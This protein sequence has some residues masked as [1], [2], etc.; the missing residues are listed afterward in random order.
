MINERGSTWHLP[1]KLFLM[2]RG[3]E[4]VPA[5]TKIYRWTI[6]ER[7][8]DRHRHAY[9]RCQCECGFVS[10]AVN[11]SLMKRGCTKSCGCLREDTQ[12]KLRT[13]RK[14]RRVEAPN[15]YDLRYGK[16]EFY[17]DKV[18]EKGRKLDFKIIGRWFGHLKV[19]S[20]SRT[21]RKKSSNGVRTLWKCYCEICGETKEMDRA[22]LINGNSLS[23]GCRNGIQRKISEATGY[24]QST[25]SLVLNNRDLDKYKGETITKIRKTA[26]E[27]GYYE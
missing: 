1:R 13:G 23:C 24:S 16:W 27:I 3:H 6:L 2:A 7:V 9:Y 15:E 21:V 5:G 20:Y 18:G 10:A 11:Y 22:N 26:R 4:T 19:L 25:V 12:R 8:A 14:R 17:E